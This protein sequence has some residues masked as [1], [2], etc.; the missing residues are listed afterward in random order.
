MRYIFGPVKS[1]RF[2]LSLGIDLSP[3]QKSCNFDCL[4]CELKKAK[5]VS[6]IK[7]E[8]DVGDIIKQIKEYIK[9]FGYPDVITVTAN[10]EPTLYSDLEKLI[11]RLNEIKGKSKTL[12]LSNGSIINDKEKQEILKKFDM[13]KISLDAADQKTFRKVNRVLDEIHV[14]DIIQG[15]IQF[16]KIYSGQLIIEILLVRN[17]NDSIENVQNLSKVLKEI[18]PDRID[19]GTI[20]RP[21]A[22]NVSPLTDQELIYLS[23]FFEG[24]NINVVTRGKDRIYENIS[25]SEDEIIQT[26]KRRPYTY[27]DIKSVFDKKTLNRIENL[28]R[29]GKLREIKSNQ[30]VFI[31]PA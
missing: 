2:G 3:E 23:G 8:P 22:Y 1:R 9:N 12:I 21:P 13:V 31:T 29:K 15:L 7:N 14:E 17:V 10:G 19:I 25:L 26:F 4:Y 16:R 6:K 30:T 18:K 24:N 20:D 27:E 5:P 11:N 28:I